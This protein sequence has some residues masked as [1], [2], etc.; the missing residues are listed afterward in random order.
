MKVRPIFEPCDLWV[1]VFI[2]RAKRRVYVFP[3]PC[4]GL[5]ISW[6]GS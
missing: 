6:G 4:V 2:D 1:G 3:V 5:V